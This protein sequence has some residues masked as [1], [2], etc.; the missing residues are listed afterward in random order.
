MKDTLIQWCDSTVSPSTGCDGCELF[1]LKR[2]SCYAAPIHENRLAK[3]LP[4]LYASDFSEVRVA[5]GRMA[6]AAKWSDLRGTE[7]PT[8]PWLN[9]L[10]RIIF[11][12]DMSDALSFQVPFDYLHAEIIETVASIHGRRHIWMWLTKQPKRMAS[13]ARTIKEWPDNLWAGT[14]VTTQVTTSRI[15]ALREVPAKVRFVSAEP[16][17]EYVSLREHLASGDIHQVIIGGESGRGARPCF[18]DWISLLIGECREFS[19]SPFV[20]QLGQCAVYAGANETHPLGLDDSHGG[21]WDEW[22]SSLRVREIPR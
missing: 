16:L 9:G 3:T 14:S 5:P 22:P 8:K 11:V 6:Q 20:K 7:R 4:H 13:F 15:R 18:V 1:N 10:P 2:R 19:V 12:S 21:N 17:V